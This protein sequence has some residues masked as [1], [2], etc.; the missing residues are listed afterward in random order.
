M[1][2]SP[3]TKEVD[4]SDEYVDKQD[5]SALIK[6][7]ASR[8]SKMDSRVKQHNHS[9]EVSSLDNIRMF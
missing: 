8:F 6:N 9:D 5:V 7:H 2:A 4:H 1:E 3:S